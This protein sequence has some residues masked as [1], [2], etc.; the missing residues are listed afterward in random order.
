MPS[1]IMRPIAARE[2]LDDDRR[3]AFER[4]IEQQQRRVGHQRTRDRQ[5]LLLAAG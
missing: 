4:L 2:L 5:H 1:L 3:Q